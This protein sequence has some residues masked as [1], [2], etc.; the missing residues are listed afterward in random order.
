[1]A[2]EKYVKH[3]PNCEKGSRRGMHPQATFGRDCSCGLDSLIEE[4][5]AAADALR[6]EYLK[7]RRT[8]SELPQDSG[9]R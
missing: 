4:M 2:I 8:L 6:T 9:A 7:G 3:L 5:R 1:M